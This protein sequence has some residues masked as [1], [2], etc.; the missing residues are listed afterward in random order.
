MRK[1]RGKKGGDIAVP[2]GTTQVTVQAVTGG[3]TLVAIQAETT[4][5]AES[6]EEYQTG[7]LPGN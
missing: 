2:G 4:G 5:R 1:K 6:Q 7:T 3:E